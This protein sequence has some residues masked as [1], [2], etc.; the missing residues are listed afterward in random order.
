MPNVTNGGAAR[1]ALIVEDDPL[2]AK[3][4]VEI[5]KIAGYVS[6]VTTSERGAKC[7]VNSFSYDLYL[8][9]VQIYDTGH[10]KDR[11]D[12]LSFAADLRRQSPKVKIV[13]WTS[14]EDSALPVRAAAI[15]VDFVPK[16]G[17]ALTR[18]YV[19]ARG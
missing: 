10:H 6:E 4:A 12:G 3:G 18:L 5:L 9:D 8:I 11:A 15:G 7:S 16:D 14:S 19:I 1:R 17:H 13:V 2:C